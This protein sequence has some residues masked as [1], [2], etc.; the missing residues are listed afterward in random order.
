MKR[1]HPE[2]T[3][4]ICQVTDRIVVKGGTDTLKQHRISF[5]AMEYHLGIFGLEECNSFTFSRICS[6]QSS[7]IDYM[8]FPW[9]VRGT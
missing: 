1:L 4:V 8:L 6:E 5:I 3:S 9:S 2:R 7:E